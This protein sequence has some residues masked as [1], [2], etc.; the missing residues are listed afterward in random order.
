MF[1]IISDYLVQ[2]L[3]PSVLAN[4]SDLYEKQLLVVIL[5][6]VVQL[7]IPLRI[8]PNIED[9]KITKGKKFKRSLPKRQMFIFE[10]IKEAQEFYNYVNTKFQLDYVDVYDN[11]PFIILDKQY[12]LSFYE[13]E[14]VDKGVNIAGPILATVGNKLLQVGDEPSE[15]FNTDSKTYRNGNYYIA[16]EVYSDAEKDCLAENS[17]SHDMV[18]EYLRQLKKEYLATHN[19]NEILFKD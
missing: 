19:Y 9:Y 4:L 1:L 14:I 15:I 11:V 13:V 10:D 2:F 7:C 17:L 8:A 12:F 5:A 3:K 16:L 18:L 6:I